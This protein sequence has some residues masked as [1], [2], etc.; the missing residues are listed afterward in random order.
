MSCCVARLYKK[1]VSL[2]RSALYKSYTIKKN[3]AF[4]CHLSNMDLI[5][6]PALQS[7][8]LIFHI[9]LVRTHPQCLDFRPPFEVTGGLK[10]CQSYSS[11]GCCTLEKDNE[12]KRKY[13][14]INKT[15]DNRGLGG[16]RTFLK[17]ILCQ[18]CSPYAAHLF[19]VETGAKKRPLPG[20]CTNYCEQFYD[21][22]QAVVADITNDPALL[23]S[24]RSKQSF[25]VT[26]R[27]P[28]PTY[29][30]PEI[31]KNTGLNRDIDR[32][33]IT[34]EGC[35]CLEKFADNLMNPLL[36]M[37]PPDQTERIIIG[38]QRGVVYVYHRNGTRISTFM[39]ISQMVLVSTQRGDERGFLGM[40]F[41]PR[42]RTNRQLYVYF[43]IFSNNQHFTR[44]SEFKVT[45]S[46]PNQVDV[47]SER[48]LLE[49]SQPF[50]NHNGGE[51][52]LR[53]VL[54]N[55]NY[56]DAFTTFLTQ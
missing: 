34:E 24:L 10:F 20:M 27:I 18:T 52:C 8:L 48:I 26:N 39:D 49:I 56:S 41:H 21:R 11:F 23:N 25:C 32:K 14:S 31:L 30:Y 37:S 54:T 42:F 53:Y 28:D 43:S 55:I 44:L 45:V 13:D 12:V 5:A 9:S 3:C 6:M 47:G 38:E 2:C 50:S 35:L 33:T 1:L 29:C 7:V 51:V 15:L 22:C 36:L 17:E 46:D 16:C 19:D 40:A 4:I